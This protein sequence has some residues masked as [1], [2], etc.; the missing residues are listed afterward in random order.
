MLHKTK[1][2]EQIRKQHRQ[3]K[4]N[5]DS[6]QPLLFYKSG[7]FFEAIF[8]DAQTIADALDIVVTRRRSSDG[9]PMPM[10]GIPAHSSHVYFAQLKQQ[11]FNIALCKPI[12][13]PNCRRTQAA[14]DYE[15]DTREHRP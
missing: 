5:A 2:T 3:L 8:E 6:Q 10:C 9:E 7:D 15:L 1:S 4:T 11:G 14:F 13:D 12:K